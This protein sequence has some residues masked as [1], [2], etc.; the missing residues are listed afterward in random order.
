VQ[1]YYAPRIGAREGSAALPFQTRN[2]HEIASGILR[3]L[4]QFGG[5]TA[6]F[7]VNRQ[8]G[9]DSGPAFIRDVGVKPVEEDR[10]FI[11]KAD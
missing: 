6:L 8:A 3:R 10:D 7:A 11:A 9:N 4:A 2:L 1:L 5:H